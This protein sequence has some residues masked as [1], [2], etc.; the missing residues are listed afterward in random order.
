MYIENE[1]FCKISIF[2]YN[3]YIFL[4]IFSNLNILHPEPVLFIVIIKDKYPNNGEELG[5][6]YSKK[7]DTKIQVEEDS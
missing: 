1:K 7:I 4:V 3:E 6:Y 2:S 5:V